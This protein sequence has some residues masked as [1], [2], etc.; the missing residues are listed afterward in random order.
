MEF[1]TIITKVVKIALAFAESLY[2]GLNILTQYN[3]L[4]F[5]L[6]KKFNLL[7]I[8]QVQRGQGV[9]LLKYRLYLDNN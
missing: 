3:V 1:V 7:E 4:K 9:F 2:K 8:F 5:I 6:R